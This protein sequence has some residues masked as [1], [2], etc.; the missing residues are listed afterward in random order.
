MGKKL[1]LLGLSAILASANSYGDSSKSMQVWLKNGEQESFYVNDVDSITFG[2]YTEHPYVE[3]NE[4]T[5]PPKIKNAAPLS[6]SEEE[7][8]YVRAGNKLATNYFR[9]ICEKDTTMGSRF[10]C[11]I[12]MQIALAMCANG[13]SKDGLSEIAYSLGFNGVDNLTKLNEYY[14]KVYL[15]M[16]SEINGSVF[17][18][19]NAIWP[20]KG[21]TVLEPF[22]SNMR[23]QYYATVRHL[24]FSNNPNAAGDTINRW[25]EMATNGLIK[26][27]SLKPTNKTRLILNNAC[28]FKDQWRSEFDSLRTKTDTFTNIFG[29]T[30]L[31]DM[32]EKE[33]DTY[34]EYGW[35]QTITLPY[36]GPY[37]IVLVLPK[38]NNTVEGAIWNLISEDFRNPSYRDWHILLK[39]PKFKI[40]DALD[41]RQVTMDLGITDIFDQL[42]NAIDETIS[43]TQIRQDSYIKL[44]E[45]G[46]EAAAVTS[47]AADNAVS[48]PQET[49][50]TLKFDR[51][52]GFIIVEKNTGMMLFLGRCTD[53]GTSIK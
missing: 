31:V 12:S 52:F 30:E 44:D 38:E 41:L 19:A 35:C 17:S 22:L 48:L 32:M 4:W 45:Q 33:V 36:Q 27:L 7:L 39:L 11:P 21:S 8:V 51:P 46:T 23:D 28:Y 26:E 40:K 15:A 50:F 37:S 6:L 18:L 3:L 14:H 10:F 29:K 16:N 34:N 53:L 5:M 2:I 47:V 43:I 42:P 9:K 13:A 49:R 25:A 20:A 24:D 1:L